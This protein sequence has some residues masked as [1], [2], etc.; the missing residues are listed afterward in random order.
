MSFPTILPLTIPWFRPTA[1]EIPHPV[2]WGLAALI[3]LGAVRKDW[4]NNALTLAGVIVAISLV[5]KFVVET[6]H[7]AIQPFGVL[8][9]TGVLVAE[10]MGEWQAKR[11]GI[12]PVVFAD[13]V[14]HVV[15]FGFIGSPVF[16]LLFYQRDTLMEMITTGQ[17]KWPGLSSYGGFLGAIIG[18][19]YWQWKKGVPA[20]PIADIVVWGFPLGWFFGRMGCFTVHDHP[21]LETDFFLGVGPWDGIPGGPIRHDL[22]LYEMLLSALFMAVTW[23]IKDNKK[24]PQGFFIAAVPMAYA[25]VRFMLDYLRLA[26]DAGGDIRYYGL[27]PAQYASIALFLFAAFLM[28][29][30]TTMPPAKIPAWAQWPPATPE[31]ES[32]TPSAAAEPAADSPSS[33][34]RRKKKKS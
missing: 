33:T 34:T 22:G 1:F 7:I 5:F 18:L 31:D 10:R 15:F 9:M 3:A 30:F 17:L 16:N 6:D 20:R 29:R 4:R 2:A 14:T 19:F 11:K 32:G 8:V 28:Y 21:G 13:F 24:L 12:D 27:T 23:S 26:D 25:P